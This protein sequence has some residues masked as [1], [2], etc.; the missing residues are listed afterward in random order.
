MS[1][2]EVGQIEDK[3]EWESEQIIERED[4]EE[5]LRRSEHGYWNDFAHIQE[6]A[7][8]WKNARELAINGKGAYNAAKR[9]GWL[10]K[11]KYCNE[12]Q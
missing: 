10:D 3:A 5:D 1:A 4:Q 2:I 11:I 8:K 12:K 9:N 6:E 7:L